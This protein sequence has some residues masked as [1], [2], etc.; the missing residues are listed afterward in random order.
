[1]TSKVLSLATLSGVVHVA[2]GQM[3]GT[4]THH[5]CAWPGMSNSTITRTPR[6]RAYST[7]DAT[8]PCE[9]CCG[10]WPAC[11]YEPCESAGVD[12][13]RNGKD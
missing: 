13:E 8:S 7:I 4:P 2:L 12:V 6:S 1:M 5:D 11:A 10:Y 3:S 9:Y